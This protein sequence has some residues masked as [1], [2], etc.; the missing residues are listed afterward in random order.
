MQYIWLLLLIDLFRLLERVHEEDGALDEL[1]KAE[2]R[3]AEKQVQMAAQ[4]ADHVFHGHLLLLFDLHERQVVVVNGDLH[5]IVGKALEVLLRAETGRE[6]RQR[7][8]IGDVGGRGRKRVGDNGWRHEALRA[9]ERTLGQTVLGYVRARHELL[10]ELGG[11][12]DLSGGQAEIIG[13]RSGVGMCGRLL[14]FGKLGCWRR[15]FGCSCCL[16]RLFGRLGRD[17][18]CGGSRWSSR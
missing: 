10:G 16:C 17:E 8:H 15:Q 3:H 9:L 7:L 4:D 13:R 6:T 1:D 2:Q 12:V 11:A 5:Q 18:C 14:F